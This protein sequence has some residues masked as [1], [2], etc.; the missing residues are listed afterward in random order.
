MQKLL[1]GVLYSIGTHSK[2]WGVWAVWALAETFA[3]LRKY[4]DFGQNNKVH[5]T[6]YFRQPETSTF[7]VECLDIN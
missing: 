6:V 3:H 7:V 4:Q 5:H 1:I 2:R